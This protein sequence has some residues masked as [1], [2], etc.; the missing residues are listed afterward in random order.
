MLVL[1]LRTEND[2]PVVKDHG[3]TAFDDPSRM[4]SRRTHRSNGTKPISTEAILAKTKKVKVMA[5]SDI[6]LQNVK[7][8]FSL[9]LENVPTKVIM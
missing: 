2:L 9:K 8:S 3:K 7:L 6:G 4:R 1:S 5:T